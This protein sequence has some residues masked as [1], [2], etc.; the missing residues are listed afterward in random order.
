MLISEQLT[1][2]ALYSVPIPE[3]CALPKGLDTHFLALLHSLTREQLW[4]RLRDE[5][6][7]MDGY[8]QQLEDHTNQ[9]VKLLEP[10]Y[11]YVF[12]FMS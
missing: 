2:S 8:V 10:I 9:F 6:R 11:K 1:L 7:T 12:F 4:V 3:V 5:F